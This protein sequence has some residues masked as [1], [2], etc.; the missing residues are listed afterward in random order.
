MSE[1][2]S[3]TPRPHGFEIKWAEG[4]YHIWYG[5]LFVGVAERRV[6]AEWACQRWQEQIDAGE[7][8]DWSRFGGEAFDEHLVNVTK[9]L[10]QENV[11]LKEQ[12]ATAKTRLA[13]LE[14]RFIANP[15]VRPGW[16]ATPLPDTLAGR[17][18]AV[19]RQAYEPDTPR[20]EFERQWRVKSDKFKIPERPNLGEFG[21]STL[22]TAFASA[23]E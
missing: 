19:M 5:K 22:T 18:A 4:G 2:P 6:E 3:R 17:V 14:E 20:R 15:P 8:P 7:P 9:E 23:R 10:E 16:G 12:L 1:H 11:G 13:A 21:L